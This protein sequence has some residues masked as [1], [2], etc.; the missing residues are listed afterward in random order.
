METDTYYING[1][2]RQASAA[3]A[4]Q[5]LEIQDAAGNNLL[6]NFDNFPVTVGYIIQNT[7]TWQDVRIPLASTRPGANAPV[8]SAFIGG[9]RAYRWDNGAPEKSLE[10]GIEVPDGINPDPIY[11]L[12]LHLHWTCG[13]NMTG[14]GVVQWNVEVTSASVHGIFGATNVY[15]GTDATTAAFEHRHVELHTFS[16]LDESAMIIGR[17]YRTVGGADTYAGND[18]FGLSIDLHYV[19]QQLGGLNPPD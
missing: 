10:F 14:L 5:Y 18:V 17:L 15:S 3:Y 9:T 13:S 1:L 7:A 16:G 11:G 6:T 4:R 8:A 12:K 19:A 2:R